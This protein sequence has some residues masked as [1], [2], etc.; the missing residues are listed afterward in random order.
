MR[1]DTAKEAIKRF[2]LEKYKLEL[3]NAPESLDEKFQ[4]Y[5][6]FINDEYQFSFPA[7]WSGFSYEEQILERV[8][9]SMS[10][11]DEPFQPNTHYVFDFDCDLVD[12][13]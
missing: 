9:N 8:E 2:L 7:V 11:I 10:N 4:Y 1:P 13:F 5:M 3:S 12:V 6:N